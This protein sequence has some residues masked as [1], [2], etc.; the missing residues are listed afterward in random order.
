M[1]KIKKYITQSGLTYEVGDFYNGN[2]ENVITHLSYNE[3]GSLDIECGIEVFKV[4]PNT[5]DSLIFD[6]ESFKVLN[7]KSK[8]D[9][10]DE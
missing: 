6:D 10:Q 3:D 7:I 5:G 2:E 4:Y 8:Y 1:E 9:T